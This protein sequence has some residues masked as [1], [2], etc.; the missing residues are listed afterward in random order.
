MDYI[1]ILIVM[2]RHF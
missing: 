2:H 1:F